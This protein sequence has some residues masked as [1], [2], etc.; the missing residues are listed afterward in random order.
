[1]LTIEIDLPPGALLPTDDLAQSL[2][3]QEAIW[4]SAARDWI[5]QQ[6]KSITA[7]SSRTDTGMAY[8]AT[9]NKGNGSLGPDGVVF[10][11]NVNCGYMID[12]EANCDVYSALIRYKSPAKDGRTLLS[13][14]AKDNAAPYLFLNERSELIELKQDKAPQGVSLY[15]EP[16]AGEWNQ[17]VISV[18]KDVL[19]LAI[20]DED[21]VVTETPSHNYAPPGQMFIGCR[22]NR[23]GLQKT[24]G[25]LVV[26]DV[27]FLP[28]V[29]LL[30]E[31]QRPQRN[32][33]QAALPAKSTGVTK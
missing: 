12:I 16:E 11:A 5:V 6:D 19:S 3:E 27:I 7:W 9:P 28:G 23:G 24:L 13:I 15:F 22:S 25:A 31:D 26:S 18:S 14:H 8:P 32:A 29:D 17:I 33:I 2:S 4:L 30:S 20:N 21:A 1:M 10:K